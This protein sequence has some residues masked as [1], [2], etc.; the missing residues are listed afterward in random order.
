MVNDYDTYSLNRKQ[1]L[2]LGV[3]CSCY[4]LMVSFLFYNSFLAF[5]VLSPYF[6]LYVSMNRSK[7]QK[8]RLQQLNLD[9]KEMMVSVA[10]ALSAGYSL[11]N[12]FE[13]AKQDQSLL[14]QNYRSDMEIELD[15]LINRLKMNQP[16]EEILLDLSQRTRL[17]DIESF[18]Q[19]VSIAKRNGGNLIQII[20]KTVDNISEKMEVREEIETMITAKKLEQ[21]VMVL[22]PLGILG[23]LKLTNSAY[24]APLYDNII[25]NLVATICFILTQVASFWSGKMIEIEV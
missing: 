1:W 2:L 15:Q 9:F 5:I 3:K 22:M 7:Y 24:L 4:L 6:I 18:A 11:E 8:L 25:G 16:V 19:V 13:A 10:S 12:S 14:H 17:E 23:Y 20:N 21:S